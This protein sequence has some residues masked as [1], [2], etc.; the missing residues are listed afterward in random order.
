MRHLEQKYAHLYP[1]DNLSYNF[2]QM[3]YNYPRNRD[4]IDYIDII[5]HY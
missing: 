2:S 3:F 1:H 5:N 4:T